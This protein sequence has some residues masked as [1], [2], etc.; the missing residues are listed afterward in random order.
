MNSENARNRRFVNTENLEDDEI[1]FNRSTIENRLINCQNLEALYLIKHEELLTTFA[2]ALNL[3]D[4]YKY[5]VKVILFLLKNLASKEN[6]NNSSDNSSDNENVYIKMPPPLI[7]NIS[8]LVADQK[9]VQGI[10]TKMKETI[11]E[12]KQKFGDVDAIQSEP[13][14]RLRG[15]IKTDHQEGQQP[16]QPSQRMNQNL[17]QP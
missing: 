11:F 6:N 13:A 4:K 2:F 5:A 10:I 3:F 17:V 15:L 14:N 7:N 16:N 12:G 9:K 1:R 8:K